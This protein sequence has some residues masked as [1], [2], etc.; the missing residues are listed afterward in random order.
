MNALAVVVV[1][2]VLTEVALVT[3][4]I[5]LAARRA[6]LSPA[7]VRTLAVGVPLGAAAWLV[8]VLALSASGVLSRFDARPPPMLVMVATGLALFAFATTRPVVRDLLRASPL[9]W[10]VLVQTMRLPIE[11]FLHGLY[12][13]GRLPVHLTFEGRNLDILVGLSAP[14]VAWLVHAG[15]IR[16]RALVA[17]NVLG[18]GLLANVVGMAITTLPGPLHLAWPGPSNEVLTTVPFVWLPAWLV[19]V[20]LVAHVASLRQVLNTGHVR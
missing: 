6:A 10:P 4:G 19:P 7:R 8:S 20:A 16:A 3:G 5:R 13:E 12:R 17:W 15:R 18:L 1:V 11:L 9:A 14:I 2:I